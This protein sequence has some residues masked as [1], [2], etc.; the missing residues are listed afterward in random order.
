[1]H[2][3]RGADRCDDWVSR[4]HAGGHVNSFVLLGRELG[5]DPARVIKRNN[6][7]FS[8]SEHHNHDDM[9]DSN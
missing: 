8:A 2:R 1:M 6:K 9:N 5:S 7:L 4:N 3:I